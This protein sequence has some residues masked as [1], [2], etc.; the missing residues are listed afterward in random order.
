VAY[1]QEKPQLLGWETR[2]SFLHFHR[3]V[4]P[5]APAASGSE[6][7]GG[8][9]DQ[10]VQQVRTTWDFTSSSN[11]YRYEACCLLGVYLPLLGRFLALYMYTTSRNV[12][13][14]CSCFFSFNEATAVAIN[15][16][17]KF[18]LSAF[19]TPTFSYY[20][21]KPGD[22]SPEQRVTLQALHAKTRGD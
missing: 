6:S 4:L 13:T 21:R 17:Y 12:N 15:A 7:E 18:I 20:T 1:F 14:Y 10:L 5:A 19:P 9:L 11:K 3:R 16:L 22:D 8:E 2:S